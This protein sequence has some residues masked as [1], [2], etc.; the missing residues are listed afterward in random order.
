MRFVRA[1]RDEHGFEAAWECNDCGEIVT[2]LWCGR[3]KRCIREAQ[4][5]AEIVE[6]IRSSASATAEE[7]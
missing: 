5:H 4:R 1:I 6:A 3:C 7:R 2:F